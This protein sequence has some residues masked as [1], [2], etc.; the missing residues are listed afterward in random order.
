MSRL[1]LRS[2]ASAAAAA[3]AANLQRLQQPQRYY[4]RIHCAV[5]AALLKQQQQPVTATTAV[6]FYRGEAMDGVAKNLSADEE[7]L[8]EIAKPKADQ[9]YAKHVSMPVLRDIPAASF[10]PTPTT[11]NNK[12]NHDVETNNNNNTQELEL[13]IRRKRL[14]YRSKQRGWLEVDLLLGT[15][16]TQHVYQL[17]LSEL[18]EY[19]DF[20]NLETI[21]IYNVITLRLDVP[22]QFQ[23][24]HGNGV[25]ERIQAW[26]R[27]S[28]L[29]KADPEKY[30][31]VKTEN[32]LI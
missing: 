32:K 16:A 7:A 18:N 29:G 3:A 4:P 13:E 28:P 10:A 25:V 12:S 1:F 21:D 30:K 24:T 20:L 23:T 26:A 31:Q 27:D 14:I 19:E 2:P 15:W 8:L 22:A 11:D 6:R 5:S 9:I 17:S